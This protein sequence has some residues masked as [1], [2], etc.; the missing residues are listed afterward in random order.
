MAYPATYL[1]VQDAVIA[2]LRLSA[3]DDRA[4][5]KDWINQTLAQAAMETRCFQRTSRATVG[6]GETT[7]QTRTLDPA[8]L[9]VELITTNR[10]SASPLYP[11]KECQLDEI[12]NDRA[13]GSAA[14]GPS[15]K[16]ALT[17]LNQV[18][19]WPTPAA[20]D[21]FTFWYSYLPDPL[22]NDND[23][24]PITEP[25]GSK[26]TEY[27]ALIQGCEFKRDI[28]VLG[29]YQQQYGSWLAAFQRYLNRKGG[30]YPDSF[31]TWTRSGRYVPSDPSTD[32]PDYA[33]G[34]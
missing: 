8:V 19:L 17:G 31:P 34:A 9:H 20:G 2:K 5:V 4:K 27:G 30:A 11:L 24:L 7:P 14:S 25:F 22:A 32:V 1:S 16:Y 33:I 6:A 15:R 21:V 29:D 23:P 12:L 28:L 13:R 18:E 26:L 10:S 3:A